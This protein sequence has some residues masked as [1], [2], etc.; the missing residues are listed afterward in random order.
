[1]NQYMIYDKPFKIQPWGKNIF[2]R[3]TRFYVIY[4]FNPQKSRLWLPRVYIHVQL[5]TTC[6]IRDIYECVLNMRE[7]HKKLYPLH[8]T[9]PK[10]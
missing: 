6:K 10:N 3:I 2:L 8:A 9:N 1:M 7:G 5:C 4:L